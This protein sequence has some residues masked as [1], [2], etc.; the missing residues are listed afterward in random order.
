MRQRQSD[1]IKGE[2]WEKGGWGWDKWGGVWDKE[3][4]G[5]GIYWVLECAVG[6]WR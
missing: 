3:G 1:G 6:V 2:G 5:W 4:G